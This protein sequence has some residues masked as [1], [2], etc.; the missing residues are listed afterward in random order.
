ML[1]RFVA[2]RAMYLLILKM[3]KAPKSIRLRAL[4]NSET[5]SIYL[6]DSNTVQLNYTLFLPPWQ[7]FY[8]VL[9]AY[10]LQSGIP[11]PYPTIC[12]RI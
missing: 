7:V 12:F 3:Q 10:L 5:V 9:T 11:C 8:L 6:V 1:M 4:C 2:R